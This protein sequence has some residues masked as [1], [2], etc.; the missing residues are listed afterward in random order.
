[1]LL[2]EQPLKFE[3][4]KALLG[5]GKGGVGLINRFFVMQSKEFLAE[6]SPHHVQLSADV[7]Q[8]F[9]IRASSL[10]D[11]LFRH[12]ELGNPVR[13]ALKL[14]ADAAQ[15]LIDIDQEARRKCKPDSPWFFVS[16]YV[17]RH[18]ERVLRLAGV[19]HVFEYG[20]DGEI[21]L[22]TLQ[23]AESFG[24]WYV[25]SFAQIFYEPPQITQ[26]DVDADKLEQLFIQ[27]SWAGTSMFRQSDM[28]TLALNVGLTPTRF[29]RALACLCK[30][31]RAWM[32]S[33]QNKPWI[34]INLSRLPQYR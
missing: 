25:D 29:T 18:A 28:R 2:M 15:C 32:M 14:S 19:F 12:I 10:L 22:D 4:T 8:E 5:A 6:N 17:L 34:A 23:R 11:A 1:M 9:F 33:H 30:Q 20:T 26:E 13:P 27:T 16:E 31:G 7:K 3:E 21:S 24:D